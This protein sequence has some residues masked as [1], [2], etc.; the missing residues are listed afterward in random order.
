[1]RAITISKFGGPE[2]LQL[3]MLPEPKPAKGEVLVRVHASAINRADVLQ[4]LGRYP[5]PKEA[6]QDIPGLEFAGEVAAV[7]EAVERWRPGDRVFG[8]A[9]GGAYAELLCANARCLARIPDNLSFEEAAAIPEAFITAYDAIVSQCRLAAGETV[10][11]TAVGSG[12]GTA[13]VQIAS[14]IG[15]RSIGTARSDDKLSRAKAFGLLTGIN[16][17][18]G[19]FAQSV[20]D[21][22][23]GSGVEVILELVGGPYLSEDLAC[24]A[25]SGRVIVVGLTG[26]AKAELDLGLLLRKRLTMIGTSLRA[27]PLEQKI[28]ATQLLSRN[29]C[30]LFAAGKLKPVIDKKFPLAE[31]AQAHA[32]MESNQNFGK[33]VL[34]S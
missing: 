13:A 5:A 19:N 33:I 4:R 28:I 27:R 1:M 21:A 25:T 15:A 32:L 10:L 20:L 31:A 22:T 6:P 11:I 9:G 30:P 2:V 29:L 3:V 17:G 18:S 34:V 23:A 26:G 12:V 14:A 16:A 8:L 24:A 7:G